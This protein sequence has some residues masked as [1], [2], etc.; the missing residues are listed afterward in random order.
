MNYVD[1]TLEHLVYL[2][3]FCLYMHKFQ[4]VS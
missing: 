2:T 1:L 4:S 3:D